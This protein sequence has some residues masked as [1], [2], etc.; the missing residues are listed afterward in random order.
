MATKYQRGAAWYL[1]WNEHGKQFRISLGQVSEAEAEVHRKHKELELGGK[2]AVVFQRTTK[3]DLFI[4]EYLHWHRIEY[5]SSAQRVEQLTLQHL[6]PF[7][8]DKALA[9]IDAHAIEHYKLQR[10]LTG[11]AVGTLVKELRTLFAALNKAVE[12]KRLQTFDPPRRLIP[13]DVVSKAPHFYTVE[14]LGVI[15]TKSDTEHA[16]IWRWF[17][18]TGLRRSEALKARLADVRGNSILVESTEHGR[19]K[20]GRFRQIPLSPNAMTALDV[21]R[22]FDPYILPRVT[23]PSLSRAFAR[24]VKRVGL[25]GSLHSLRHTYISHLVMQ[26][27]DVR[28][29]QYLAGHSTI[30]TTERYMHLS[31]THINQKGITLAL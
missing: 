8:G 14:E 16:A 12:W 19:T 25:Q 11:V 3:F 24:T 9:D 5:P 7:F 2:R 21:L 1:Q 17:A 26:G 18:N 29:V 31:P 4:S 30:T 10:R 28:T 6:V 20:S 27:V 13:K 22:K 23:K 15:Y